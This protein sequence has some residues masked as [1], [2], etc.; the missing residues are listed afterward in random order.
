MVGRRRRLTKRGQ[1]SIAS[2]I[3]GIVAGDGG[4]MRRRDGG[5]GRLGSMWGKRAE[6]AGKRP[7]RSTQSA[8]QGLRERFA[9]EQQPKLKTYSLEMTLINLFRNH[10]FVLLPITILPR[11]PR[12]PHALP[13][14]GR[15]HRPCSGHRRSAF[16]NAADNKAVRVKAAKYFSKVDL[17]HSSVVQG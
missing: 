15:D 2:P 10:V 17:C 13:H 3:Y 16:P 11:H 4:L 8:R 7:L 5:K 12:L 14:S 6:A 9:A 1:G